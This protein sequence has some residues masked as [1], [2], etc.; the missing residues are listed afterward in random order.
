ME[1]VRRS[2]ALFLLKLKEQRRMSQ[3]AI[4]DIVD[5][6]KSLFCQTIFRVQAGV[7]A[8]LADSGVD[9]STIHG[10]DGVF[11][12]VTNPFEGLE[13][14]Y[15]QEKYFRNTLG[16]VVSVYNTLRCLLLMY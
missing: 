2:S 12:D 3:V 16:L 11:E 7:S 4:D 14:T 10:L 8:K 5:G 6:C 1:E 15:L 13:T 9:P